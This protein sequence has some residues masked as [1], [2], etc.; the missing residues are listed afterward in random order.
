MNQ[1]PWDLAMCGELDLPFAK[2]L[3]KCSDTSSGSFFFVS[4]V[5]WLILWVSLTGPGMPKYLVKHFWVCLSVGFQKRLAFELMDWV[6]RW[7]GWVTPHLQRARTELKCSSFCLMLTSDSGP[8][9]LCTRTVLPIFR[10]SD[11]DYDLGR[12]LSCAK[13]GWYIC[14]H[15]VVIIFSFT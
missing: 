2:L 3:Q 13:C 8:L 6:L 5:W 14:I 15:L 10:P 7:C 1:C 9:C 11:L 12:R 4:W